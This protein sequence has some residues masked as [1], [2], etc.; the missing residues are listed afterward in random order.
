MYRKILLSGLGACLLAACSG[1]S[2]QY[3]SQPPVE[4]SS[5][6][7][8]SYWLQKKQL[9]SFFQEEPALPAGPVKGHVDIRYLI[10][11]NGNLFNPQIVA[12]EPPGV[13]DLSALSALAKIHYRV[14]KSNPQAIP[15]YVTS[16]FEI[17]VN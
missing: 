7:L 10:D 4:V 2:T 3:L 12:S 17:E 9:S 8:A 15:V 16:R 14:A 5:E 1:T 11:S 6:A 13:L